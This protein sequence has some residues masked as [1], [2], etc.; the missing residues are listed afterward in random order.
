[1]VL[2]HHPMFSF[3]LRRFLLVAILPWPI[4]TFAK[5][6]NLMD[7]ILPL[8]TPRSQDKCDGN[9]SE[10]L[11]GARRCGQMDRCDPTLKEINV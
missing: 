9:I 2:N 3:S 5:S 6:F 4:L 11:H 10:Y 7:T 1:M 8:T